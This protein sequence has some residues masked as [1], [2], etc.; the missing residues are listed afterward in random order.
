MAKGGAGELVRLR[1]S[2][3]GEDVGQPVGL[4]LP[5]QRLVRYGDKEAR[6]HLA[7]WFGRNPL[8]IPLERLER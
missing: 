2:P 1:V 6:G 8:W 7:A 4:V 5:G 3:W